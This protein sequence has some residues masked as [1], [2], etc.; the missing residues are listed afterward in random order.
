VPNELVN[1]ILVR[2]V[3][4]II[5]RKFYEDNAQIWPT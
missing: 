2:S 1:C 4:H 3:S 5:N